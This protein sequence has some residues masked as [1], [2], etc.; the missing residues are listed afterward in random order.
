MQ[1]TVLVINQNDSQTRAIVKKLR[2]EQICALM[3]PSD[4]SP[5]AILAAAPRGLIIAG[6]V[7]GSTDTVFN[8]EWLLPNLPVLAL[9]DAALTLLTKLGGTP[10][11]HALPSGL[12]P[13]TSSEAAIFHQ[14][15]DEERY[16]ANVYPL[17]L[18]D[19]LESWVQADGLCVGYTHN[20]RPLFGLQLHIEQ[21]DLDAAQV[22]SSFATDVCLC[23][24]QWESDYLVEFTT[25]DIC[26]AAGDAPVLA[27]LSGGVD[28]SVCALLGH[29]AVGD[30]LQCYFVDTGLLR[31]AIMAETLA[32]F[33]DTKGIDVQIIDAKARFFEKLKGLTT[34]SEKE[35]AIHCLLEKIREEKKAELGAGILLS[36]VN[37]ADVMRGEADA[38]YQ[39]EGT[40]TP[41]AQFFKDEIRR[42]GESLGLPPAIYN[43]QP[44]PETG[45]ALRIYGVADEEKIALLNQIDAI[46]LDEAEKSGQAK[47]LWQHFAMLMPVEPQYLVCL[48]AVNL[49]DG[50]SVQAA[51][52]S[53]ELLE[54]TTA[55]ILNE[56]PCVARVLYDF[57]GRRCAADIQWP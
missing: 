10:A 39:K 33:R 53:F 29:L 8:E 1:N 11:P 47:K 57:T 24:R 55:R 16:L 43:R 2:A 44:F 40:A 19:S 15:G 18:S 49:V 3:V 28:S 9:G 45:L 25:G 13:V 21:N 4:I 23:P 41:L 22:L 36:A 46:F 56:V 52:L 38:D 54:E 32:F 50:D 6:G 34:N 5:E 20:E 42:L 31:P 26:A 51:R 12:H 30:R 27:E 35:F 7:L 17:V 48:R 37:A 14:F